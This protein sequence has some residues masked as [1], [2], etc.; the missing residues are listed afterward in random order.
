[1]P[2]ETSVER[3]TPCTVSADLHAETFSSPQP[4]P[5]RNCFKYVLISSLRSGQSFLSTDKTNIMVPQFMARQRLK[6]KIVS[7]TASDLKLYYEK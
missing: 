4:G 5:F 2:C 1:M 6:R 3:E 7:S